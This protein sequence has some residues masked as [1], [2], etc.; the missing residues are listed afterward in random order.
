MMDMATVLK[1]VQKN[2]AN[3]GG[4]PKRVTID[5]ESAGSMMVSAMV[6]SPEGK[7][8]FQR[9]IGQSGAWMGLDIAHMATLAAAEESG[10]KLAQG[11][12]AVTIADLRAK[13]ADDLQKN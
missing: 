9:A 5:G 7:G 1:W 12:G 10:Q 4:D 2:I 3:F 6:G 11:M 8:L 13:T